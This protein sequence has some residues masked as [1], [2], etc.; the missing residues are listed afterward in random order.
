MARETA[1]TPRFRDLSKKQIDSFLKGNHVGRIAFSFHDVVDIRPI[2]YVYE[3][4]WLFGR[5]SPSDKLVTLRHHQWV[6]FE[7]DEVSG[8]FDWKSVVAHGTFYRLEAKGS[9]S[10]VRLY[11]R[12]LR[13]VRTLS[14][15]ALTDRD[16]VP[17]RTE[18]FGIAVDSMTGRSCST[19]ARSD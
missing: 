19:K 4:G 11:E 17:F 6:A 2:H 3:D 7:V 16:P 1:A 10:D 14:P 12:G 8:P 13:S 18:L 9:K 5:T 15:N